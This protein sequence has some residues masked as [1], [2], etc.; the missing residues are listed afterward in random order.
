VKVAVLFGANGSRHFPR[1]KYAEKDAAAFAETLRQ[2]RFGFSPVV[3][4]PS[5][6]P[7]G[8]LKRL[9]DACVDLEPTDVFLCYLSCHGVLMDGDLYLVVNGSRPNQKRTLIPAAQIIAA[10][11]ECR[12]DNKL[13]ILD[14][15]NAGAAAKGEEGHPIPVENIPGLKNHVTLF[16]SDVFESAR[17]SSVLSASFLR[18]G[19]CTALERAPSGEATLSSVLKTVGQLRAQHVLKHP[20]DAVPRP[21]L[22]GRVTSDFHFEAPTPAQEPVDPPVRRWPR[23]PIA[24]FAGVVALIATGIGWYAF[25]GN[26]TRRT[27]ERLIAETLRGKACALCEP[28][29]VREQSFAFTNPM[30]TGFVDL[31]WS[32]I[33]TALESQRSRGER[34]RLFLAI[35]ARSRA[36]DIRVWAQFAQA[37]V[38][39]MMGA[40]STPLNVV[41]LPWLESDA[42]AATVMQS[43]MS[44]PEMEFAQAAYLRSV[45]P[46]VAAWACVNWPLPRPDVGEPVPQMSQIKLS[47]PGCPAKLFLARSELP[48]TI[49][50]LDRVRFTMGLT[51]LGTR[52]TSQSTAPDDALRI[53]ISVNATTGA[54]LHFVLALVWVPTP[55]VPDQGDA[56][57]PSKPDAAQPATDAGTL[58]VD[59]KPPPSRSTTVAVKCPDGSVAQLDDKVVKSE[60]VVSTKRGTH[61][62]SC[63]YPSGIV[64][65]LSESVAVNKHTVLEPSSRAPVRR[66]NDSCRDRDLIRVCVESYTSRD[67]LDTGKV[68]VAFSSADLT[69]DRELRLSAGQRLQAFNGRA[70]HPSQAEF[71]V[72]DFTFTAHYGGF[73]CSDNGFCQMT[74]CSP[75]TFEASGLAAGDVVTIRWGS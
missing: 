5:K 7:D 47:M 12:A 6:A 3:I 68:R 10:F 13:L 24:L 72:S 40:L 70:R 17:E 35:A 71:A 25:H 21:F 1:L 20:T 61:K 67:L 33:A 9:R 30:D 49:Q 4:G 56:A 39:L 46:D 44:L 36:P 2:E 19:L 34:G 57:V 63:T 38:P 8:V 58:A 53:N 50:E 28:V 60:E 23:W 66:C 32:E 41:R 22:I 27:P 69:Q 59:A 62:A 31:R 73:G 45:A 51:P 42:D 16:A 75:S 11:D 48:S 29:I 37:G 18:W 74:T 43:G 65:S 52:L 54:T 64:S 55:V 26:E 15:C 14:C